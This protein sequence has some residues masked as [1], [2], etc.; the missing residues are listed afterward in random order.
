[1]GGVYYYAHSLMDI[2]Y[3][4]EFSIYST[5]YLVTTYLLVCILLI[6]RKADTDGA[7]RELIPEV[8]VNQAE[9]PGS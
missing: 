2:L 3:T 6:P 9:W 5:P 8:T 7:T 4:V 1:M